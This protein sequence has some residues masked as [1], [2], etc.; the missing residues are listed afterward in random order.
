MLK[1]LRN[2]FVIRKYKS[3][4]HKEVL[5]IIIPGICENWIQAYQNTFN[6]TKLVPIIIRI[7]LL[8]LLWW[9]W[10]SLPMFL[11]YMVAYELFLAKY[12]VKKLIYTDYIK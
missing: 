7:V 8:N 2:D 1:K 9:F 4:D 11:T 12:M 6:G 5:G 10:P 3:T